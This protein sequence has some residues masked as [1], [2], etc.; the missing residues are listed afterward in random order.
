MNEI[1]LAALRQMFQVTPDRLP[2]HVEMVGKFC[3]A[4]SAIGDQTAEDLAMA[5]GSEGASALTI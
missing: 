4:D 3:N 2:R 1:Q 5:A